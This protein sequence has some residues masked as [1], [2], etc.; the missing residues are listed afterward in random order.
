[1][2]DNYE[3]EGRILLAEFVEPGFRFRLPSGKRSA[4]CPD[5]LHN[6]ADCHALIEALREQGWLFHMQDCDVSEGSKLMVEFYRTR[7]TS[8][9]RNPWWHDHPADYREGV[10]TLAM[11]IAEG[12]KNV[13]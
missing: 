13:D 7:L 2:V 5:P 9:R 3:P 12:A 6:H 1:M 11:P 8:W 10:V 4:M